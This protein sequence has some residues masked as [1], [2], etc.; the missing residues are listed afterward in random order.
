EGKA[1]SMMAALERGG[2]APVMRLYDDPAAQHLVWK[3]RESGLAATAHVPGEPPTG[4]GWGGSAVPPARAR[5][6]RRGLRPPFQAHDYG[7][8]LYGHFGDGCI[9]TRIDFDL[10][11][12]AGI[13]KYKAFMEDATSLVIAYGGSLSGEHGDGQSRAQFLSK[14]FGAEIVDAFRKFKAIW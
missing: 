10:E 3:V 11:S 13:E 4:E 9:H 6:Y 12:T 7:C 5:D 2:R 8:A 1:R 14:M